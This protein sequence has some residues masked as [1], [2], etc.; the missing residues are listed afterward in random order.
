MP[1]FRATLVL[2]GLSLSV[3]ACGGGQRDIRQSAGGAPRKQRAAMILN[4]P[5]TYAWRKLAGAAVGLNLSDLVH[6]PFMAAVVPTG[7]GSLTFQLTVSTS[8]RTSE[9]DTG[10]ITVKHVNHPQK[11][12]SAGRTYSIHG[13]SKWMHCR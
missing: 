7:G 8:E 5:L 2:A 3:A 11:R 13:T 6:L 12:L 9:P 1:H 4:Y 10:D